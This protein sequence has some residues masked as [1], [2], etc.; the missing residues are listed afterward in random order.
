MKLSWRQNINDKNTFNV[1][2]VRGSSSDKFIGWL[3]FKDSKVSFRQSGYQK[4]E[5]IDIAELNA[6]V[7]EIKKH[8]NPKSTDDI[9]DHEGG[10]KQG[11][12]NTDSM[13]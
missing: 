2:I 10:W 12:A 13:A 7:E 11:W 6:V 4:I 3:I 9:S 8:R 5:D 1:R